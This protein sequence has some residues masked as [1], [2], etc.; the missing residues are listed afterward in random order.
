M[1]FLRNILDKPAALFEKGG[2]LNRYYPLWEAVDTF[3]YTPGHVTHT[4][5][6]VRDAIDLKR[7]MILVVVGLIPCTLMAMYNTGLQANLAINPEMAG[8]LGGWQNAL[9][10][11]LGLGH[12]AHSFLD[13]LVFGALFFLPA[14]AIT[15]AVGGAWETLFAIVRRHE[16]NEGFLVTSLLFPLILPPTIPY[17]QIALGISFGV[18]I[19]K[20]IFGGVG[21]NIFNP[22]LVGRAF[23]FFAYPGQISGN[24]WAAVPPGAAVDGY[25]GATALAVLKE[26][27]VQAFAGLPMLNFDLFDGKLSWLEAFLGFMPG[28]MGET[29]TLG[30]I[31]GAIVILATGV[32]SWRIILGVGLGV[33]AT[34][35]AIGFA[36][37]SATNPVLGTPFYWHAVLGGLAFGAV[38]MATDPVSAAFTECGKW[39]Y[40]ITIGVLVILI[41]TFNPAFPESTMLVILFM[42]IFAPLIDYFVLQANVK[43]RVARNAA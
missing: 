6:H 43:R 14:Y 9:L 33:V 21:M 1:K 5:S 7:I 37:P 22:A 32:A 17:W 10:R 31:L 12:D 8:Q 18:V 38:F 11:L 20:E 34:S 16:I 25:T 27:G 39:I 30:C 23:L 24:V 3:L 2:K 4:A 28:S 42:N 36:G 13:N 41:R 40:G 29:S 19:G 26:E 15:L 35:T